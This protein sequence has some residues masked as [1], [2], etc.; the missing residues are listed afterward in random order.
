MQNANYHTHTNFSDGITY[1]EIYIEKAIEQKLHSLGFSDHAPILTYG[2]KWNMPYEKLEKYYET[3]NELNSKYKDNIRILTSLEI[4]YIPDVIN[5]KSEF[6][7]LENLN[8]TIGSVHYL[9]NLHKGELWGFELLGSELHRGLQEIFKGNVMKLVEE[10]YKNMR[11]M[12]QYFTPDIIGHIDRIKIINK[13]ET[14]FEENEQWYQDEIDETLKLIS[15]KRAIMEVNTKGM[16]A[17][18]LH[19]PYPS[20]WI[21]EKAKE[22]CIPIILS[23]DAHH[24]EHLISGFVDISKRLAAID[25]PILS[26]LPLGFMNK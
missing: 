14:L 19:D 21:L 10:Y 16:F 17:N 1:P 4:D 2:K 5:P 20:F 15:Q 11:E 7:H 6:L 23:S 8:Y 25:Y 12:I 3:L 18:E 13:Q 9:G 26:E 22:M 24:P